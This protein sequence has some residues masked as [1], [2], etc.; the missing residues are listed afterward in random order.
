MLF[1]GHDLPNSPSTFVQR[2]QLVNP[3][4]VMQALFPNPKPTGSAVL[5]PASI[6]PKGE[7]GQRLKRR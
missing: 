1:E 5:T 4:R 3:L 6:G 7:E 2:R